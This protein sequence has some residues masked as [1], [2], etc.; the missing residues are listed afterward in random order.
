MFEH[1]ILI[2]GIQQP[3]DILQHRTWE[4]SRLFNILGL[5]ANDLISERFKSEVTII[6]ETIP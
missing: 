3:E 1:E 4:F 2:K 5:G 6:V